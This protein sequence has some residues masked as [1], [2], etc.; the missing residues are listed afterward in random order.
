MSEDFIPYG[1][2]WVDE[3]DVAA[4]VEALRSPWLTTGPAVD[5]F[6]AGL[7]RATGA[8]HAVAV[9]TGTAALHTAYFALGMGPGDELVTTPL[10]FAATS[11][12]ALYLGCDVRF[13][14]VEPETG[15]I[16]PARV[17]EAIGP[18]TRCVCAVDYAG[19][20]ADYAALGA[21]CAD[22]GVALV[23][24]ASHS[25]GATLD[26]RPVG[27]LADLSTLSFHPVKPVT[28]AEGGAVVTSDPTLAQRARDFR[29]HG[30]V[31]DRDRMER[32][33]GP[34]YYEMQELGFNH[35]LS[36]VQAALGASQLSR[37]DALIGRRRA[38]AARYL[39]ALA[40]VAGLT[41]PTVRPGVESGWHLFVVRVAPALRRAFFERLRELSLGVQ[42]HY[43]PVHLQ[44]YYRRLGWGPGDFPHAEAFYA[45]AV[46]LPIYPRMS[47]ADVDA[48]IAR[49]RRAA[50]ELLGGPR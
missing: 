22:A 12:A 48:V 24:D 8:G 4:V 27:T 2:Q 42:V 6:E 3:A 26:G 34:W 1:S 14:D 11:N 47:D 44:P 7:C 43:I 25:L 33:E 18:R 30:I 16:D 40:D 10:T 50:G 49:V 29:T 46:S 38:I 36:D 37:L 21:I 19:H 41:L 17:A 32:D 28:T 5:R 23:A 9:G 39:D 31:R 45:G 20:P 13:V 15:L 35:R